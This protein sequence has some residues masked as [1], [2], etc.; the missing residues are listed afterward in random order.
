[1]WRGAAP[2]PRPRHPPTPTPTHNTHTHP[3][4]SSNSLYIKFD[5]LAL[6]HVMLALTRFSRVFSIHRGGD[7]AMTLP[8]RCSMIL[9][10][11]AATAQLAWIAF[12][13]ASYRRRR[14]AVT[15]VNRVVRLG[16]MVAIA[17]VITPGDAVRQKLQ[18]VA[19][20]M[21]PPHA[22]STSS[23]LWRA[24]FITPVMHLW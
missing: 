22:A 18:Y 3:T 7:S 16:C 19:V 4:N 11:V 12:A 21:P 5:I 13:P 6:L 23:A 10:V 2:S 17:C 20:V 24:I 14:Y 15:L 1:M 8:Q 9:F